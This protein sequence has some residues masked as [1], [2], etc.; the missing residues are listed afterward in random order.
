MCSFVTLNVTERENC[1][2]LKI[3]LLHYLA[4]TFVNDAAA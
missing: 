1:E 2:L 4:T 3:N